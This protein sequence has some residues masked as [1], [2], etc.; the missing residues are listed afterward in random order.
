MTM[1][2][3]TDDESLIRGSFR[4]L[5]EIKDSVNNKFNNNLTE[6]S[7]GISGDYRKSL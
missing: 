2:P 7:M 6:L 3:N 4:K 1:A 5:R